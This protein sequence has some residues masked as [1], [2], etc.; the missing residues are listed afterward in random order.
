MKKH[1]LQ[2]TL[3]SLVALFITSAGWLQESN[4]PFEIGTTQLKLISDNSHFR[5]LSIEHDKQKQLTIPTRWLIPEDDEEA[6]YVSSF[7]YDDSLTAL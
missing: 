4:K 6:G 2:F 7:N 3:L 5:L 1:S